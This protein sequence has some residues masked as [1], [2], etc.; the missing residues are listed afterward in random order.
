MIENY[1]FRQRSAENI[2]AELQQIQGAYRTVSIVDDNFLADKKRSHQ[3]FDLILK[4]NIEMDFHIIGSRVDSADRSLY[5]KMKR[6]GVKVMT[7]GIESGNQDVLDYYRK[8]ITLDQIRTAVHL[9][10]EMG[11]FMSASFILGGPIET[12]KHIENTM[13]FMQSLPLDTVIIR[14]FYYELGSEVW[15]EAVHNGFLKEDD[16]FVPADSKKHLGN[17]S[18]KELQ[19]YLQRA[20]RGFYVRPR[21]IIG[22]LVQSII[23][24]DS[25]RLITTLKVMLSARIQNIL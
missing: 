25:N 18:S 2:L 6:A 9:G 22:Q 24:K 19:I 10:H 14:P 3:I 8:H 13:K 7:L 23:T 1:G 4:N 16:W 20:Y 11:F 5:E 12:K 15:N 21:Y 17:F